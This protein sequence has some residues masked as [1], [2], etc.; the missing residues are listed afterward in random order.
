MYKCMFTYTISND[1]YIYIVT[2]S[3]YYDVTLRTYL[4]TEPKYYTGCIMILNIFELKFKLLH[5]TRTQ[6]VK[7][8]FNFLIN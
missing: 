5:S 1:I 8:F 3:K 2:M 7:T 6:D 4:I